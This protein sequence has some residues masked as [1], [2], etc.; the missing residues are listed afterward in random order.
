MT[1]YNLSLNPTQQSYLSDARTTA[2]INFQTCYKHM[3]FMY[4]NN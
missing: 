4:K 1:N 2:F 3:D